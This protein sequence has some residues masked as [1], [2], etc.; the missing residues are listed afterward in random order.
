MINAICELLSMMCCGY[1]IADAILSRRKPTNRNK[2]H[3]A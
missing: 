1:V 3:D 2:E